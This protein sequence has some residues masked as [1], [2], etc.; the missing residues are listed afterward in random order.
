M[1]SQSRTPTSQRDL[2]KFITNTKRIFNTYIKHLKIAIIIDVF[3]NYYVIKE[4]I[5]SNYYLYGAPFYPA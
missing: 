3:S 5:F 1:T 2:F 4:H